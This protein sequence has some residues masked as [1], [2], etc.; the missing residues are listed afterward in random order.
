MKKQKLVTTRRA[1]VAGLTSLGGLVMSGC[2]GTEPPTYGNI[3]RMGDLLTYKAHRLLLP[4]H[5]LAK[6]YSRGDISSIAAIGNTDPGDEHQPGFNPVRGAEYALLRNTGFADWRLTIEGAVA[7]PGLYSLADLKRFPSR[8]QITKLTCEE[9]WTAITEWTGV[10]LRRVLEA[11]GILSRAR[12]VNFFPYDDTAH[13]ID[14]IDALHP[15]TLLAYG[16]NGRDLPIAHGAPVRLRLETQLGYKSVK[17]L[18][19]IV[20]AETF[21]DLGKIGALRNGWSWYAGI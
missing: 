14:M 13:G 7:R 10:T 1:V 20:V 3:L 16:M 9:G 6:E 5:S 21:D 11:A 2:N 4:V 18:Q 15:Q 8:T 12:Y 17:Y 19:R